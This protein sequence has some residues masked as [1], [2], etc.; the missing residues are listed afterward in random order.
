MQKMS[1]N[2]LEFCCCLGNFK[3]KSRKKGRINSLRGTSPRRE[4]TRQYLKPLSSS[5]SFN[6]SCLPFL[7]ESHAS[8]HSLVL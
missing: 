6:L 2:C 8:F 1:R 5:S 3:N 4:S 7:F